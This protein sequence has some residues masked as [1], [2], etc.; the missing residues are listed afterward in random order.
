MAGPLRR[1]RPVRGGRHGRV[2]LPG[3]AGIFGR[4]PHRRPDL[5][6]QGADPGRHRRPDAYR[7]RLRPGSRTPGRQGRAAAAALPDR[8]LAGRHRRARRAGL[9]VDQ[10]RR[11][12]LQPRAIPPVGRQPGPPGGPLPEPGRF[13]GWRRRHRIHGAHPPQAGRPLLVPGR[14]AHC[15]GLRSRVPRAWRAGVLVGGVQL[16]AQDGHGVLPRHRR[17]RQR[18]HQPPAGRFLPALP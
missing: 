6:R 13:Q 11:H 16:R 8:S 1:H 10:H 5:R 2:L 12:R 7:H 17:Q 15:R 18:H 9:Q 4:H 14:P 3:S